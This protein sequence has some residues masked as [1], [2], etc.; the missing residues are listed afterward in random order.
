MCI[1]LQRCSACL[2]VRRI[3]TFHCCACRF[4]TPLTEG[5]CN[6]QVLRVY[7]SRL[8]F[9]CDSQ[10]DPSLRDQVAEVWPETKL[11]YSCRG[12]VSSSSGFHR[13]SQEGHATHAERAVSSDV[14][15]LNMLPG[16]NGNRKQYRRRRST[17]GSSTFK[18]RSRSIFFA[19]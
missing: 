16:R 3:C 8:C 4:L 14:V 9:Y 13:G 19:F 12:I 11:L 1:I 6:C 2:F 17:P 18:Q 15:I 7:A 5:H 10:S